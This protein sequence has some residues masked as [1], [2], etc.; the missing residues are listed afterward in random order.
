[1]LKAQLFKSDRMFALCVCEKSPSG[2]L[3]DGLSRC[4]MEIPEEPLLLQQVHGGTVHYIDSIKV[5]EETR[6]AFGDG[7][8][9]V[10]P[11]IAVGISTADCIPLVIADRKGGGMAV[12]HCG[13]KPI[14]VGIIENAMSLMLSNTNIHPEDL[15]CMMGP[16]ILGSEY[17][18][19]DDVAARFPDSAQP[20]DN[21]KYLLDLPREIAARLVRFGVPEN[22]ITPPPLSTLGEKW[23]PS[24]RREGDA[25]GRMLTIAWFI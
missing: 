24:Y 11:G 20:M 4:D 15:V 2:N 14:A 1:M 8:V 9:V 3:P 17:E 13:W 10:Q 7:L 22:A 19:G 23:L 5:A 18:V 16:G 12:L 21:G 25:A 6:G